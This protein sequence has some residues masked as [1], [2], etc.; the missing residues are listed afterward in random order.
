M[1]AMVAQTP[2]AF[3][4]PALSLT[5]IADESAPT[6]VAATVCDGG[7]DT[8]GIQTASVIVDDH[9][10]N[11]ARDKSAPTGIAAVT[12]AHATH[13]RRSMLRQSRMAYTRPRLFSL[14][15]AG[16]V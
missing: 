8:A 7:P 3:R 16:D 4:Q 13:R 10:R 5:T 9:R 14:T 12:D 11:A 6:E 1:S 2:L 15:R